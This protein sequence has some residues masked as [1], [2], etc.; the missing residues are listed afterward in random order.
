MFTNKESGTARPRVEA[1]RVEGFREAAGALSPT[2][3]QVSLPEKLLVALSGL[4]LLGWSV[5]H[6]IG[7]LS[8]FSGPETMNG[9]A[10]MLRSTGVVWVQRILLV[11]ALALH[12]ILTVHLLARSRR[13]RPVP[14]RFAPRTVSTWAGRSMRLTGPLL[15]AWLLYHVLHM[16]GPAHAAYVPGDVHHNLVAGLENPWVALSYLLATLLFALHLDH[17]TTSA[18]QTL[19]IPHRWQRLL[20]PLSRGVVV[21]LT[22]GFLAPVVAVQW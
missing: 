15:G 21:L 18:W 19:G 2:L 6:M 20:R 8:V 11:A 3:L 12:A 17:G 9:Y 10:A 1:L 5:L 22:L 14:Y 4:F 16:Y 13:A 7:N